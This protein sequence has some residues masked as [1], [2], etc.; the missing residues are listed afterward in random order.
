MVGEIDS[1]V[2]RY[3]RN[4]HLDADQ[5]GTLDDRRYEAIAKMAL[6]VNF[7]V[8][9]VMRGVLRDVMYY[10]ADQPVAFQTFTNRREKFLLAQQ[11]QLERYSE[12]LVELSEIANDEGISPLSHNAKQDFFQFL[13]TRGFRTRKASLALLEGGTVG[14]TWRNERWRLSLRFDGDGQFGYVLLDRANPPKGATG[15]SDL[16]SFNLDYEQLDVKALI[17]E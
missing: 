4:K 17:T 2:R 13:V 8:F 7:P 14:A 6:S 11:E 3:I 1:H 15:K 5:T 16:K 10:F 9:P 12:R